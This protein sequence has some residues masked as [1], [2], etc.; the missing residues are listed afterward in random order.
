M[1]RLR[2]DRFG[3][4]YL[5]NEAEDAPLVVC[6]H[7]FPDIPGTWRRLTESLRGG[8][9]RIVSPWLPGY[10][11]SSLDG[12]FDAPTLADRL[13]A[14][15]DELSPSKPVRI[16]GH[17]WGSVLAQCLLAKA[18]NRFRAAALLAVPHVLAVPP[19]VGEYPRQL[20]RSAY[21]ALFQLPVLSDAVLKLG[22]FAFA[23]WLWKR[24]SPGFELDEEYLDELKLCLHS[25]MPAPLAYYRALRSWSAIRETRRLLAAGPIVV[26]TIYLHGERDGCIGPEICEGQE[27]HF[28]ALFEQVILADAGHFVH[29]ERP[30]EVNTAI[31]RWFEAH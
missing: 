12:P 16:V 15:I 11:P 8:G 7:G 31:R 14:F 22:D 2:S 17:D 10:A 27:A 6:L 4:S 25:S 28:S 5:S 18:P 3:I 30:H 29:L 9:Y 1:R 24:W 20:A 13:L 19:N 21:M 26:P 23:N